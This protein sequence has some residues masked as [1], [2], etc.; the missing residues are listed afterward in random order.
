MTGS[1]NT[2]RV[3]CAAEHPALDFGREELAHWLTAAGLAESANT[4]ADWCFDLQVDRAAP[5]GAFGHEPAGGA[6]RVWGA[7]ETA[8]LHAVYTVLEAI[9]YRFQITGPLLP[10]QP[11][12]D[13]LNHAVTVRPAVGVRGIRQ[14]LN[15]PMDISSY[16]LDE[17]LAYIRNLA[18]LRFNHITFHSYPN[19][20]LA[21]PG[22]GPAGF[23]FYGQRHPAPQSPPFAGRVRNRR[24]FCIPEIEPRFDAWEERS[25]Q[26]VAWLRAVMAEAR[27]V[28][29]Q[30]QLSFEPRRTGAGL[31]E[32]LADCAAVF[33]AYPELDVLELMTQETGNWGHAQPAGEVCTIVREL[34]GPGADAVPGLAQ[35]LL[36]DQP[37]LGRLLGELGH[38]L[39]AAHCLQKEWHGSGPRVAVGLYC[40]VARYLPVCVRLYKRAAEGVPLCLLPGH[41]SRA[42]AEHA[43][44]LLEAEALPADLL[45]YS[46]LEFDGLM[47]L[48]QNAI[49]GIRHLL[50]AGATAVC[51]NHW[52]T[53]ENRAAA[54]YA[55]VASLLGAK[56]EEDFYLRDAD[57]LSAG[58]ARDYAAAMRLIGEA[59]ARATVELPNIGFCYVGVWGESGTGL[60]A[61]WNPAIVAEVRE[62]FEAAHSQLRAALRTPASVGA[63]GPQ[64][65]WLAFLANRVRC[66]VLYLDGI[67]AALPVVA[68]IGD[69]SPQHLSAEERVQVRLT[70]NR[71]LALFRRYL[72]LHVQF[73]PDRG[74]EGTL[75]SVFYTPMSV[76]RRI[77][78]DYGGGASDKWPVAYESFDAPPA[79]V[80]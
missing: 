38:N 56:A 35:L 2:F 27:R 72:R 64:R 34:F 11:A 28:G 55:S 53:A 36:D 51:F 18:R 43:A 73:M 17:A 21:L 14:H 54:R 62:M 45:Y 26:A 75:V 33:A 5:P 31:S 42:V 71:A 41:G 15:F 70:C 37:D 60:L 58:V 30:V 4:R 12:L 23:F 57:E 59:D 44:M 52:R 80:Q 13:H 20:F 49:P 67:A 69:R 39:L 63:L 32:T 50:A 8:A 24:M 48:Q 29:L 6:I 25:R 10:L 7:D 9:G 66:T 78:H 61:Q 76:L 74:C 77:R 22:Q 79:P 68:L 1:V 16:P 65:R 19:Q 47:F 46:W 3:Q 40:T